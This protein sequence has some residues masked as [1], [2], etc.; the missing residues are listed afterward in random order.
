M[1]AEDRFDFWQWVHDTVGEMSEWERAWY[2]AVIESA[3]F[4]GTEEPLEDGEVRRF[5]IPVDSFD[6]E[7][8]IARYSPSGSQQHS[9]GFYAPDPP[10]AEDLIEIRFDEDKFRAM[11]AEVDSEAR[12]CYYYL[13]Y[14]IHRYGDELMLVH[15]ITESDLGLPSS[16]DLWPEIK[17]AITIN[18]KEEED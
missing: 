12:L 17:P 15:A 7:W 8:I 10:P 1:N 16:W 13:E 5:R 6:G 9:L 11:W 14:H 18:H 3:F 4:N 2:K